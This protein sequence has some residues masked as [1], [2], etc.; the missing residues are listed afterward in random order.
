MKVSVIIPC[1]NFGEFIEQSILS[2]VNQITNFEYEILVRDDS[3]TDNSQVNIDRVAYYHNKVKTYT[4]TENWGANKN[5]KFLNAHPALLIIYLINN[6]TESQRISLLQAGIDRILNKGISA[7]EIF[8]N[9]SVLL[10]RKHININPPVDE[11]L[12]APNDHWALKKKGRPLKTPHK[13]PISSNGPEEFF[14][15]FLFPK[16]G[17]INYKN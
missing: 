11:F 9:L 6:E 1:Y 2:A 17:R 10:N 5:V 4:P 14:L 12:H 13:P 16:P 7:Q 15:N 8:S 3:S